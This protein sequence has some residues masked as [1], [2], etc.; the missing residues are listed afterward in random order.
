VAVR[1]IAVMPTRLQ[2]RLGAGGIPP[3]HQLCVRTARASALWGY[4]D[5]VAPL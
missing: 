3:V 5:D 2:P 4:G 1:L